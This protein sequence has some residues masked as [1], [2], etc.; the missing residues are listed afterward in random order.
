M[1]STRAAASAC[2]SAAATSGAPPA[3][4]AAAAVDAAD[5][6]PPPPPPRGG[7]WL[8]ALMRPS[9]GDWSTVAPEPVPRAGDDA[10]RRVAG[11]PPALLTARAVSLSCCRRRPHSSSRAAASER[12]A[13][14]W[15][16]RRATCRGSGGSGVRVGAAAIPPL[17][18]SNLGHER[19]CVATQP[20]VRRACLQRAL[21]DGDVGARLGAL[22]CLWRREEGRSSLTAATAVQ[23]GRQT[24]LSTQGSVG[25][26]PRGS[27]HREL[28]FEAPDPRPERCSVA[29]R[30]PCPSPSSDSRVELRRR[31]GRSRRA[32]DGDAA[33]EGRRCCSSRSGGWRPKR[34]CGAEVHWGAPR[35]RRATS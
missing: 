11:A 20:R 3:A 6:P 17:P 21:E 10:E 27:G 12:A 32:A 26:V 22:A 24:H 7:S 15:P 25:L 16:E 13:S 4:A 35:G 1:A 33:V 30:V 34:A 31:K 5:P 29:S 9:V 18:L 23:A 2:C 8:S 19:G 14:S 28:R